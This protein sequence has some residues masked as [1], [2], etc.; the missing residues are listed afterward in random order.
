MYL[1]YLL[2]YILVGRNFKSIPFTV[3]VFFIAETILARPPGCHYQRCVVYKTMTSKRTLCGLFAE[4]TFCFV[5]IILNFE[6]L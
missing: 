1:Y 2:N 3:E 4:K 5:F 6:Q